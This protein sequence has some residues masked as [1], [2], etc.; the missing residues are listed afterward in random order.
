M[1]Q[2]PVNK[3]IEAL[4]QEIAAVKSALDAKG[5]ALSAAILSV[6]KKA[7]RQNAPSDL[8]ANILR[9]AQESIHKALQTVLTNYDSPIVKLIKLVVEENSAELKKIIESAFTSVMRTEDFKRAI[10]EGCQHKV[11]RVIVSGN[12]GL[13]DKVANDLRQDPVFKAKISVAVANVVEECL[14]KK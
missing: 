10:F 4:N 2:I 6:E 11:S 8:E 1:Q 13:F 12:D 5:A 9:V 7:D 14:S 3:R